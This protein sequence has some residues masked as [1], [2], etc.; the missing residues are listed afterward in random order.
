[1]A[2]ILIYTVLTPGHLYP[3][4]PIAVQLRERGHDV[5]FAIASDVRVPPL[6]SGIRTRS[7]YWDARRFDEGAYGEPFAATLE[8]FIA[9]ESPDLLLIDPTFWG[10]MT[11]AEASGLPWAS[12]AHNPTLFRGM[13]E[14]VR[15][16]GIAPTRSAWGRLQAKLIERGVRRAERP[17]L[18]AMNLVRGSRGLPELTRCEEMFRA[19]PL[20]LVTT[21]EPF[22]YPRDDWPNSLRFIGPV[23]Y[24]QQ[25]PPPS[26]LA[27]L[28]DRPVVLVV[29]SSIPEAPSARTWITDVIKA[30]A[31]EPL[32]IIATLPTGPLPHP[33]P[34]NA[35]IIRFA[36]HSQLLPRTSCCQ[37]RL[38]MSH[39][40]RLKCPTLGD[41]PFTS[42]PPFS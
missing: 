23:E 24:V 28:D 15:G 33:A 11:V 39:F 30:L 4:V 18:E 31:N 26:W 6:I 36:P 40:H 1:M 12:L 37:R 10:G 19:P 32:Q 21:A 22:E 38:R 25:A 34:R 13:K 35:R 27:E 7:A 16:P 9:G 17:Y 5:V 20:T 42:G 41:E 14:G 8:E 3:F 29:G 2:K